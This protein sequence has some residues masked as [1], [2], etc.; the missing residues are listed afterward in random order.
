VKPRVLIVDD[1]PANRRAFESI[2]DDDYSVV[3]AASGHQALEL[4]LKEEFAVI[5]LDVRMPG[6]DGFETAELLAKRERSSHIP[7]IFLSAYDQT[8]LQ[9]K[10]GYLAGAMDFVFSP[11]D[12][13]LL[14]FK[15]G[16]FARSYLRNEAMRMQV[17]QLNNL[18]QA[19]QVDLNMRG[20]G[21]AALRGKI[22]QLEDVIQGLR[23]QIF[24]TSV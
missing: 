15:V 14:K 8:V 12:E 2:L 5:L 11:V 3:L 24:S 4:T 1:N 17:G 9:A 10:R 13:E 20:P 16:A 6:M 19:L 21:E 7:I 18:V 23:R 22:K